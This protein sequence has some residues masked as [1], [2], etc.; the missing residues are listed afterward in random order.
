MDVMFAKYCIAPKL[1]LIE[2]QLNQDLLPQFDE[3]LFCRFED[4]VPEDREQRRADMEANLRNGVTC[5]NEERQRLGLEPVPWGKHP[6]LP[7]SVVAI[8][9]NSE[10]SKNG[11]DNDT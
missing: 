2:G 4:V 6:F 1:R 10:D 7:S 5:I 11:Q 8:G 9:R 3:R